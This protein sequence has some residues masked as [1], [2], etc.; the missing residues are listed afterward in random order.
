[1]N[2]EFEGLNLIELIDLLEEVPEPPAI[3]MTPQTPGWI[4]VGIVLLVLVVLLSRWLLLRWRANAYRREALRALAKVGEDPTAIA[5]IL[6]RTALAAFPRSEVA[7]LAGENWLAF[8]DASYPGSDFADGPG[9][10]IAS[11]PYRAQPATPEMKR[12]AVDWVR[13][14]KVPA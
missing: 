8:L 6:R 12:I 13:R 11:A 1:M 5:S 4:V 7:S 2:E 9:R 3:S 10:T 14:H